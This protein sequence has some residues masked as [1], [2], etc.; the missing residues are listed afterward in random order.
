[1]HE[2][3]SHLADNGSAA[4]PVAG[5]IQPAKLRLN[6]EATERLAERHEGLPENE[7]VV[8]GG[9]WDTGFRAFSREVLTRVDYHRNSD[10]F[11]FDNEILSQIAEAGFDIAEI[12]CPTKYTEESSSINFR[13]SVIYGLGVV[14]VS[15]L[16]FLRRT[17]AISARPHTTPS[18]RPA[19][20]V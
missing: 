10:D 2:K 15:L 18:K 3:R 16:H 5:P 17:G 8:V 12:T 11:I 14:R 7:V 19:D 1:M 13:R 20:L 9:S 4:S 6:R